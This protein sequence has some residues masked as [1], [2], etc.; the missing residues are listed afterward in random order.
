VPALI[1]QAAGDI[2]ATLEL[3]QAMHHALSSSIMVTLDG[4]RTHGVY[5]FNGNACVD[6]VVNGYLI[7]GTLP[8]GDLTC[9]R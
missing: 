7:A 2:N 4:V 5:L 3:G 1:V 6:A 8:A 9:T